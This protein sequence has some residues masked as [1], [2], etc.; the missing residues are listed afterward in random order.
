[1]SMWADVR[2]AVGGLFSFFSCWRHAPLLLALGLGA[3]GAMAAPIAFKGSYTQD[4]DGLAASGTNNAWAN[5]E[6]LTG[7][8]LF[9]TDGSPVTSYRAGTGNTNNGAFYSFDANESSERALGGVGSASL[10]GWIALGATNDTGGTVDSLSIRFNGEQWRNGGNDS[11]HTMSLEYGLGH[12]FDAVTAWTPA[13]AVLDWASPVTGQP[14]GVVDGNGAGRVADVGGT[15]GSLNWEAGQTLWLRWAERDDRGS[16]H[17]LAI[18]DLSLTATTAAPDGA[19]FIPDPGTTAGSSDASTAIALDA[20]WMIVGDDEASVLRVYPRAGGAAVLAWD[21]DAALGLA[22]GE[23]DLEASARLGDTLY[24]IGSHSNKKSGAEADSR[25]RLFAVNVSGTGAATRFTPAGQHA[26]LEQALVAWDRDN[27]HGRGADHFGLAASSADGVVP[28]APNGFSIEGLAANASGHLLLGFRAPQASAA[29][30]THALLVPLTNPQAVVTDAAAPVFGM[31][32]ELDLGGRG[33][34]S[35]ERAD[36]GRFLIIA[37]PAGPATSTSDSHH[38][39]LYVWDGASAGASRLDNALDALLVATQGS[40]EALV[41]PASTA[42]GTR[43]QLLQDNGDTVWPGKAKPSKDLP[44]AEQQFVGQWVTLG[45][46]VAADTTP[47]ALRSSQPAAGAT[48]VGVGEAIVLTF[49]EAVRPGAGRFELRQGASTVET[50]MSFNGSVV[51]LRPAV[52]LQPQTTYTLAVVGAAVL[53]EAGN[54]WAGTPLGFTTGAAAPPANHALLITEVNSNAAGGDFFELFNHGATPIDLG[55]WRWTDDS[56]DFANGKPFPAGTMLAAGQTLVVV[57]DKPAAALCEAWGLASCDQ[58]MQ[59]KGKGLGKGDAVIVYDAQGR[60]VAGLN[61]GTKVVQGVAPALSSAGDAPS[62]SAHAGQAL[63]PPGSRVDGGVS[64][65]WDGQSTSAPR[66]T[67]ASIGTLGAFAQPGAAANIGSP[68]VPGVAATPP[69]P[70]VTRIHAIQGRDENSPLHGQRVTV[71]AVVTAY[72]P[73]LNG[74]FMQE[75]EADYDGDPLT[76]EGV[77]V[78]YGSAAKNPGVSEATVGQRVRLTASVGDFRNQ[79]QLGGELIDFSV[80]GAG[81][82]PAPARLTLPVSDM[83]LLEAH[84]GMLVEVRAASG[85]PLVVT[86]N[87]SLGRYGTVALAP[88]APLV[89]FTEVSAPDNQGYSEFVQ[90]ARRSQ[91]LLD[92]GLGSQNPATVLARG[93][94]PLSATNTLRTGDATSGVVGVLDEFYDSNSDAYQTSYRVQPTQ[95]PLFSGPPRP[96]AEEFR[97]AVGSATVKVGA[98]NVLNFFNVVGATSGSGQVMFTTP[99]GS[100]QGIRGAN[101]AEELK[102]QTDKIVAMLI[103]M[104]A[105]AIGLMEIQ[106]NGFGAD[107]ALAALTRALNASSD[108]PAGAVYDYVKGPF[109]DGTRDDVPGVGDDAITGAIVYRSDRVTPQGQ[110]LVASGAAYPAFS[111]AGGNRV[112]LAQTFTVPTAAGGEAFTLVVNHFKSKG[113][114]LPGDGN[115]GRF[116]GQGNNNAARVQ[117]AHQLHQWLSELPGGAPPNLVLLGDFNAYSREDPITTLQDRGYRKVSQGFSYAFRGLAGSLDHILVSPRLIGRVGQAVKWA[118][119]A[120]EPVVLDYN[121]EFRS[122]AQQAGYYGPT[123]YRASDHN[124]IVLGLNFGNQPPTI[125]GVPVEPQ[126][127]V[128]GQAAALA[129]LT[130]ADAEGDPLVLSLSA[131]NGQLLGLQDADPAQP[132]LQLAGSAAQINAQLAQARFVAD[133]AGDASLALSLSDGVNAPVTARYPLHATEV[134]AIDEANRFSVTPAGQGAVTGSIAGGGANCRVVPSPRALSPDAAGA[135]PLP[136]GGASMPYGLL[137]LKTEGCDPASEV[138]VTLTY[139]APLPAGTEY[140]K[141]S[142]TAEQ[143]TLHWWRMPATVQG[144]TVTFVLRDGGLGDD[145]LQIDGRISDPGGVVLPMALGG[146][147]P[148]PTLSEWALLLLGLLMGAAM[149]GQTRVARWPRR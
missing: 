136:R 115:P 15:L 73:G 82:L 62:A 70:A 135:Q 9:K 24:F 35:I 8:Y 25:E 23:L 65:V 78:Y 20:D 125:Q 16:D 48:D 103:G 26:G 91:I 107:S 147:T 93:G 74:F 10:S 41:S 131:T 149:L 95:A 81:T 2:R 68:G 42:P 132:G 18:D 46:P 57:S 55:G 120:E 45:H 39:V 113:S 98:A 11:A 119:N 138:T 128:A 104:D 88:N 141:W 87:Y 29:A 106:N 137:E 43:V 102:R 92:D 33:I 83:A 85:G 56:E 123:A 116:D 34:R 38:F 89:Q 94:Q 40:F 12:S 144:N 112:P 51:T 59:V 61:Y 47:P 77:F 27:V 80:L 140:W 96:T 21:Y 1:M 64:A 99:L 63:A 6:T 134:P 79:T 142:R 111:A 30:R 100:R 14:A 146:P 28:E 148:V 97:A 145:D 126:A 69:E 53:D 49:N 31:P 86:D 52:A 44:A 109:S 122:P 60:V 5:G 76:S 3:A 127:L 108:K 66:Y 22:G 101:N 110:A 121:L 36:D 118:I 13:G 90:T 37:G 32:I 7:W 75:Q 124:P 58:V 133:A 114:L 71:E 19:T 129:E 84:E 50:Q 117:A 130:V 143:P 17:G 139:P 105:D 4:F 72:M 67:A 54:P